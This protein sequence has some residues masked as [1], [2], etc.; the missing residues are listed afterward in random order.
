M[1]EVV[2]PAPLREL[3]RING[4]IRLDVAPPATQRAVLTAL[5]REY[6]MLRGT[7]RDHNSGKRRAYLRFFA[8][9]KDLSNASPD[10]PLPAA[11]ATG[12]EPFVVLGAMSGG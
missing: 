11:V 10:A 3:A 8:C 6:P 12:E 5:E 1:I 2:L 4:P 9:G 7:T